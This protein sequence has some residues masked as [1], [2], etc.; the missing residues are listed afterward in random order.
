[1][2]LVNVSLK[3]VLLL[4]ELGAAWALKLLAALAIVR[5]LYGG[6]SVFGLLHLLL[7]ELNSS[8]GPYRS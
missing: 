1:M 2:A 3:V 6:S 8:D 4:D 7:P 5:A